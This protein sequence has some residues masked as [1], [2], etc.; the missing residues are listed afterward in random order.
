MKI[1]ERL[2]QTIQAGKWA[3][4][5]DLDK[6]LAPIETRHGFPPKRRFQCVS[7]VYPAGVLVIERDWDSLAAAEAGWVSVMND[8]EYIKATSDFGS[9]VA[10]MTRE[11]FMSLD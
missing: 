4:L 5:E 7:G 8:Q 10:S 11:F 2:V 9:V 6:V 1:Q 3:A